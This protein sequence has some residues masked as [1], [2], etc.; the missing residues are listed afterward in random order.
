[1][2]A[3]VSLLFRIL[4]TL[5]KVLVYLDPPT[6][7]CKKL[8]PAIDEWHDRLAAKTLNT[9]NSDPILPTVAGNAS[10]Q[11]IMMLRKTFIQDS[12]LMMELRPYHPIWQHSILSDPTYLSLKRDRPQIEAQEQDPAHTLLQQCVPVHF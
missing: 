8:V 4:S 6:S 2:T 10:V 11:V 12:V 5:E 7:L 1:M 9:V 3:R